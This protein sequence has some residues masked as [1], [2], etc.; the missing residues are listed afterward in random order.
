V[1]LDRDRDLAN[2]PGNKIRSAEVIWTGTSNVSIKHPFEVRQALPQTANF[3]SKWTKGFLARGAASAVKPIH[4][5]EELDL[6]LES[7]AHTLEFNEFSKATTFRHC[8]IAGV[9]PMYTLN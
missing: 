8:E 3:R 1:R 4:R 9:V 5:N 2:E 6:A 7:G